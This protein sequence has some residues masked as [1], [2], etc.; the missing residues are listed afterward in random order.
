[1]ETEGGQID[2]AGTTKGMFV[3]TTAPTCFTRVAWNYVAWN[4]KRIAL[5]DGEKLAH[6]TILYRFGVELNS[7]GI[8]RIEEYCFEREAL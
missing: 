8:N 3:T 2:A 6:L 4:R 5:I 1:M 7:L